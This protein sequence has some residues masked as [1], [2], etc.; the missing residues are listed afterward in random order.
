MTL[1]AFSSRFLTYVDICDLE[2]DLFEKLSSRASFWGIICLLLAK[3]QNL[4]KNGQNLAGNDKN[5]Q[6][7]DDDSKTT[8]A[9]GKLLP[10][11]DFLDSNYP[12][13]KF[14]SQT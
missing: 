13:M 5:G 3:S 4:P 9:R 14:S 8:P 7:F 12:N 1:S 6:K 11:I 2:S 10:Q